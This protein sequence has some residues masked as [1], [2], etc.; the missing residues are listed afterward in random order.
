MSSKNGI[1]LNDPQMTFFADKYLIHDALGLRLC[2]NIYV[3]LY[4][5][6]FLLIS[7]FLIENGCHTPKI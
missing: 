4:I 1:K 7:I 6:D 2:V 3:L 5:A